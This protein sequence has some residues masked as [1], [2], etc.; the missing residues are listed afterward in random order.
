MTKMEEIWL[1]IERNYKGCIEVGK[2]SGAE[3]ISDLLGFLQELKEKL[4]NYVMYNVIFAGKTNKAIMYLVEFYDLRFDTLRKSIGEVYI[5]YGS[6]G[7]IVTKLQYKKVI[8][9]E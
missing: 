4:G 7:Y 5:V 3:R 6:T 2:W 8:C 9:E 1:E